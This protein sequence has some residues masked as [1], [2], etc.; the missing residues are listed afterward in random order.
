ML[1][2][3]ASK[4]LTLLNGVFSYLHQMTYLSIIFLIAVIVK[5]LNL[6]LENVIILRYFKNWRGSIR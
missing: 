5:A 3:T 1:N 2:K 6:Q 4:M